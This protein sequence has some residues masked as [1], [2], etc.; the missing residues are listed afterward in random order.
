MAYPD[1]HGWSRRISRL[2]KVRYLGSHS[3]IPR[4]KDRLDLT[5]FPA[6]ISI[7][8]GRNPGVRLSWAS[9]TAPVE[10]LVVAVAKRPVLH[11]PK[12]SS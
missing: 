1:T 5:F 4:Q 3:K 12:R 2:R 11:W 8:E 10:V 6:G 9:I 7:S